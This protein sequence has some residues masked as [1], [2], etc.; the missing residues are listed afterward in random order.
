[1]SNLGDVH[2]RKGESSD[3][4]CMH[5]HLSYVRWQE[6]ETCLSVEDAT[7]ANCPQCLDIYCAQTGQGGVR[8]AAE[9]LPETL[10]P[11][12]DAVDHPSH[13][14]S[15]KI[16]VMDFIEDQKLDF[17]S[18]NVVKYVCRAGKKSPDT[19]FE[20]V[21]KALFYLRRRAM[22]LYCQREE[23]ECPKPNEMPPVYLLPSNWYANE[24]KYLEPK[25]GEDGA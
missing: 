13:Y 1:M 20:D 15:G 3:S 18:G 19:E 4:L 23:I 7:S 24:E 6:S 8:E 9:A 14:N 10:S 25:R 17:H 12:A 22:M 5:E 16:E 21:M 11:T 2:I